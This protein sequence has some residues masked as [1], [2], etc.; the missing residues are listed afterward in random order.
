M[1]K[2]P[3]FQIFQFL[4]PLKSFIRPKTN[5]N[6]GI[7]GAENEKKIKILAGGVFAIRPQTWVV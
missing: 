2:I 7:I 1:A 5:I 4:R 3:K 6:S